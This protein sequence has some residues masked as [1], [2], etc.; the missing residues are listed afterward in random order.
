MIQHHRLHLL[1]LIGL[2][3]SKMIDRAPG[4]HSPEDRQRILLIMLKSANS[5]QRWPLEKNKGI[6]SPQGR[7]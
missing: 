2:Q 5:I 6:H 3:E 7:Q 4:N 1:S